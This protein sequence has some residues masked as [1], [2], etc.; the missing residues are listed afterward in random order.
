M[1]KDKLA[2]LVGLPLL[3]LL[4]VPHTYG[5]GLGNSP[6][7][8]IGIGDANPNTGGVRQRGMGGVGLAAPNS[9]QINELNPALL[10]YTARTTYE[11][12]VKG[13]FQTVRNQVNSQ[14]NG[15]GS[16]DTLSTVIE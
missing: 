2:A 14:R 10:Y 1:L 12:G 15:S 13:S 6:Y 16:L 7:S 4:A 3:T 11:I 9:A 5:Q 8:R